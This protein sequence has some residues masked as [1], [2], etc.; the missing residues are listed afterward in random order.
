METG[1]KENW[2]RELL[3]KLAFA[4]V[5][6]S[7]KARR[8]GIGFRIFIAAYLLL[9]LALFLG[10][11]WGEKGLASKYTALVELDG[12]IEAGGEVTADAII[13][14]L[15]G[16][17]EDNAAVGVILRTNSPGG[18]PVQS[19]Y[20]RRNPA[21]ARKASGQTRLCRN[22]RHLCVRLLLRGGSC[23]QDLCESIKSGG[24]DRGT[25]GWLRVRG[26][27]EKTWC[28][29]AFAHGWRK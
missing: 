24:F 6:E 5:D 2:E 11:S 21:S 20:I 22:R 27:Y 18:S 9:L 13:S 10:G 19:A 25:Y 15:R 29:T 3:E 16:A 12:V 1:K 28:G 4:S 7:R 26:Q 17:F 23:Q 14:G 8:W